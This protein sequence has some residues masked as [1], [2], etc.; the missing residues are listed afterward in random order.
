MQPGRASK[1]AE[2]NALF[3]A[4]ETLHR[5]SE[6]LINDPLAEAFLSWRY[7]AVTLGARLPGGLPVVRMVID[8]GWPGVRTSLVARTRLID[9][10]I[11]RACTGDLQAVI[12]GAGYDT[13]AFRLDCLR[14]REVF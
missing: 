2:Q 13:R 11:E 4:L 14:G 9:E 12:L 7:R 5:A 3:R 1:T 10:M 6:R 8:Q